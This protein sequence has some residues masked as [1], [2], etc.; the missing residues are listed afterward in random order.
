M[1][2][3]LNTE[4]RWSQ[5]L[6]T[7]CF[8]FAAG[9]HEGR[10]EPIS[11]LPYVVHISLVSMEVMA[12]LP[13]DPSID[14]DLAVSC[15]LLHDTLE[16]TDVVYE[17]LLD[18]FGKGTADGVLALT[19]GK[20]IGTGYDRLNAKNMRLKDSLKRIV[21]QPKEIWM[22]KMADRIVNLQPPPREWEKDE[23]KNYQKQAIGIYAHLRSAS[24]LLAARLESKIMAYE[25]YYQARLE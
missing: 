21:K 1:E 17:D 6:Y 14:G 20:S 24:P 25:A 19:P 13:L 15:A 7:D 22:V 2:S 18:Q 16:D 3:V 9:A 5:D 8:K 12:A 10:K 4:C 11:G 23:I